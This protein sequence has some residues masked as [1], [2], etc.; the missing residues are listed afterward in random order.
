[1][2]V[3]LNSISK[4]KGVGPRRAI[5]LEQ[6][7]IRTINDLLQF[8]PRR[9]EDRSQ[10]KKIAEIEAGQ[11]TSIS[12]LVYNIQELKPR[13]GLTITKV[14]LKDD[15]GVVEMVWFN[16]SYKKNTLK[17]G[18]PV[19]AFGRVEQKGFQKQ[20]QHAEVEIVN[21]QNSLSG[22]IVPIY[23]LAEGMN[24]SLVRNLV[25]QALTLLESLEEILP[26]QLCLEQ[27]LLN[28]KQALRQIHHPESEAL[29]T[30][31]RKRLVFEELFFLQYGIL[32]YKKKTDLLEKGI[33]HGL[34]GEL[35]Q[36]ILEHLPFNLTDDQTKALVDIKA[37][38]EDTRPMHR[39]LQG[40]VGSGKTV[41]A[42]LALV[43]TVENGYQ[44]ALMAPTEILAEQHYHSLS[45]LLA[46]QGI[47]LGILTGSKTK[48][49]KESLLASLKAGNID[50]LIGTHALIQDHVE[51]QALG[52]VVTDEQHRFG[53]DQRAA[54][55][56]K[57]T[58]PDVLVMTATPIPRTMALTVYGD[59]DVS[60]IRQ[61][62]P[63]RKPIQTFLRG[64]ESREKVYQY[65]L[66]EV[67]KGR[68][69]YI[70]CPLIEESDK[71]SAQS[72]I[73]LYEELSQSYFQEVSCG[74]VHGRLS[75]S[76]KD[77]V[78]QK[79][80]ANQIQVLIATTVIEVGVNVPNASVM[81]IEGADRFGLAQLHQLRGR[82]G[83]GE[84]LSRCILLSQNK[85]QDTLERLKLL[86]ASN[87]GFYLA[88]QDLLIRGPGQFFGK[89]QH[90]LPDLKIANIVSDVDILLQARLCAIKALQQK[91]WH[92]LLNHAF[93]TYF[94]HQFESILNS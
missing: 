32:K 62:P 24:Q 66:S 63:G 7:G 33:K 8:Y 88:E 36:T 42:A 27:N 80:Y 57:G 3:W 1:M 4:L 91:E 53:V 77:Q 37:D 22:K 60:V 17:V 2:S 29:L 47:R 44:G 51:F 83:R 84:L 25:E 34:D 9:Y 87:D 35:S 69:A 20:L 65:V 43:K 16:Q 68:Q 73:E 78:M 55:E 56:K 5:Q 82:I 76:E 18:L 23:S 61:M 89:R 45:S 79:F 10:L 52:L 46:A 92:D 72:A 28:R 40:D 39:L 14:L 86:T 48:K 12:G 38:M 41:I 90:G 67:K 71:L 74:L 54:L 6:L 49:Q 15:T 81:V 19:I 11:L 21:S 85:N 58:A 31:A 26:D 75:A 30:R 59:L 93:S 64:C 94:G 50:I 70:V 13:R